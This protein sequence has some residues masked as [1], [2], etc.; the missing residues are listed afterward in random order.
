MQRID[1]LDPAVD[2]FG[3]GKPG[4]REQVPGVSLATGL[5]AKWFNAVQESIVRT[6]EAAG[7]QLS[8]ADM[9]QF[10]AALGVLDGAAR[11]AAI[12]TAANDAT[13]K[14]SGAR[15]AA[16][17]AA[18]QDAT[19]K[20][21]TARIGA[22]NAAAA[23]ASAKANAVIPSGTRMLFQQTIAP[24]GWTKD[25]GHNDKA[26]RV[27]S[28]AAGSGGAL[29]FSAAFINGSVGD[30]TL[31]VAQIPA[32]DHGT[33][34]FARDGTSAHIGD[35]GGSTTYPGVRSGSTGG[36]ASHTHTLNLAVKYVDIII[37]TKN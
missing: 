29:D 36:G 23:D 8:A 15:A 22:I 27:V 21:N 30:T 28:G 2:L 14:A 37:A 35:G 25:V 17:A 24:V 32:H 19:N 3:L 26:L 11:D 5:N 1:G 9:D 18:D 7:L 31:T 16:I 33:P 34:V 4:F 13:N 6:I 12:L 10:V 20:A